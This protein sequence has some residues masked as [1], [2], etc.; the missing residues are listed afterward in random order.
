MGPLPPDSGL[1]ARFEAWMGR[2]PKIGVPSDEYEDYIRPFNA[3]AVV[4][5]MYRSFIV[6]EKGY[7]GLGSRHAVAGRDYVCVL[8]GGDVPFILRKRV[9]GYWT[10]V[11]ESYVHGIMD[12]GFVRAAKKEDLRVFRIR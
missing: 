10:F 8:R 9:D 4:R 12:G 5:C 2:G 6:T 1:A 3:P 11:G 7:L